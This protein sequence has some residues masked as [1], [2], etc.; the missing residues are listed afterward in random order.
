MSNCH[1]ARDDDDDD[2]ER[3]NFFNPLNVLG[4]MNPIGGGGGGGTNTTCDCQSWI[5]WIIIGVLSF[6]IL[7]L[8]LTG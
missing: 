1:N 5:Y 6:I 7:I 8:L 3:E 2:D 4:N